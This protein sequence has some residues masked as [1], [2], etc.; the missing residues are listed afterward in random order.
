MRPT[1]HSTATASK[2]LSAIAL[3]FMATTLQ[4][5]DNTTTVTSSSIDSK[6]T[7]TISGAQ[8]NKIY[9]R[10]VPATNNS[11]GYAIGSLKIRGIPAVGHKLTAQLELIKVKYPNEQNI[12][13]GIGEIISDKDGNNTIEVGKD[14]FYQWLRYSGTANCT[15]I[16]IIPL[17]Q[18]SVGEEGRP[19]G[20][21]CEISG[22]NKPSYTPNVDDAN[23]RISV[24]IKYKNKFGESEIY[25]STENLQGICEIYPNYDNAPSLTCDYKPYIFSDSFEKSE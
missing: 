8:Y 23:K 2:T 11:T 25:S 3:G 10:S 6:G 15:S 5:A 9:A 17:T 14:Y 16:S 13:E 21:W 19:E 22:A 4:A 20:S 7:L 1:K 18:R 24:A 12:Y